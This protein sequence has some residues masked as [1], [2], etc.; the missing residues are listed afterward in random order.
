MSNELK[1]YVVKVTYIDGH[2]FDWGVHAF[3]ANDALYIAK[4]LHSTTI[5]AINSEVI[6]ID[7]P[8]YNILT[9]TDLGNGAYV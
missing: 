7:P 2:T 1:R 9:A 3:S 5:V 4:T 8:T 6:R